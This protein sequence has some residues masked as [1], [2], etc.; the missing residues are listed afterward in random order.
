VGSFFGALMMIL[1]Y[2]PILVWPHPNEHAFIVD[3]HIVYALCLL[4]LGAFQAG[5]I[6]GADGILRN[7]YERKRIAWLG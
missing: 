4:L 6:Y 3:E 2:L 1:Y 5:R 7:W